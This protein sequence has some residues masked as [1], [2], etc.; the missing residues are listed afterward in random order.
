VLDDGPCRY[1]EPATVVRIDD[2][3]WEIITPGVVRETTLG[4]L[5]SETYLFVCTGNTCRSPMAEGLFRKLLSEKLQC[6]EDE[7][8]DRGFTV[9]SAGL[10][11]ATGAPAALE[12]IELFSR[13]DIDLNAHES[14]PVTDRLLN[15]ADHIYT[16]TRNH[17]DSILAAR[18]DVADRVEVLSR[19]GA[20]IS[21]PIG[22]DMTDYEV[23]GAEIERHIRAIIDD[24]RT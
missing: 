23:C 3:T 7:L 11:A 18:P 14:Q 21:D 1:G 8:C 2:G 22:G 9:A 24:L 19:D 20:D 16:M 10:A 4:R 6:T 17:R 5:A 13:R 12:A 15:Q